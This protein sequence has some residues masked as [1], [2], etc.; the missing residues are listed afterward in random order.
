MPSRKGTAVLRTAVCSCRQVELVCAGTPRRVYA[1]SCAECQRC[2]GTAF[3]YRAIYRN[4]AVVAR[5]GRTKSWR[6]TGQSGA[7]L[8]QHFCV[9]CGTVVFMSAEALKDAISVSVGCFE[10]PDFPPPQRLHWPEQRHRWLELEAF[11]EAHSS[12]S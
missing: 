5:K 7:W 10:D 12:P 9:E 3:S 11:P 2:T 1:C 4:D 6:R 8:D